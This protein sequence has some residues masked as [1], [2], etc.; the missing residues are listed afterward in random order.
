MDRKADKDPEEIISSERALR[1]REAYDYDELTSE[2]WW[3]NRVFDECFRECLRIEPHHTVMDAGCGTGRHLPWLARAA[4]RVIGADLSPES[5]NVA[6]K[7]LEKEDRK[8]V[9]LVAADLRR[10]PAPDAGVD[11]LM[12]AGVFHHVP[13]AENRQAVM[14]EFHRVLKP[15]GIAAMWVF[16]WRYSIKHQKEGFYEN[17]PYRFAF[18]LPEVETLFEEAGFAD[19]R[20]GGACIVSKL[21]KAVGM[22]PRIQRRLTFTPVGR[23]LGDYVFACARKAG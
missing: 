12:C 22:S 15:G 16:R 7:R 10:L 5:L 1:D 8:R 2:W 11:R 18:T 14:R 17:G 21:S 19:T 4:G 13:G 6:R 9:E 20:V 3:N 23:A